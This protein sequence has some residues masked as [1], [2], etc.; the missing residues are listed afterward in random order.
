[1]PLPVIGSPA[2]MPVMMATVSEASERLFRDAAPRTPLF[3]LL[4]ADGDVYVLIADGTRLYRV[5]ADIAQRLAACADDDIAVRQCFQ[6]L[7]LDMPAYVDDHPPAPPPL[8]AISLAMAQTCNLG[9]TYCYAQQGDFGETAK[10][11]PLAT[12][13]TAV[14]TTIQQTPPGERVNIAF[15]GGEPLI[16]REVL[17][18]ATEHAAA[19]GRQHGVEVS[20]SITTNGTLLREADGRFFERHGFAVTISVDG[21]AEAHDRLRPFKNGRGSYHA[22]LERVRPLLAMQHHMQVSARVTVTPFN[23]ALRRTL[24]DL[25]ELG[26]H[27][28]G[29]SPLLRSPSGHQEMQSGDL[30][31]MLGGCPRINPSHIWV[32]SCPVEDVQR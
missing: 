4:E 16:G 5:S 29:F 19:L 1:M 18:A 6:D 25:I 9:C 11:M 24:D 3:H 8:R 32:Q 17:Q 31:V 10:S 28:V 30:S 22:L 26:F 23:I 7:E 20:F 2:P 27:S 13:R 12:A 14:E 15:L 21:E